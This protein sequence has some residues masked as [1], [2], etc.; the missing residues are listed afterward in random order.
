MFPRL[1]AIVA[2]LV[3]LASCAREVTTRSFPD[4][5]IIPSSP[6]HTIDLPG[7]R[8]P[9]RVLYLGCGH[10]IIEH[11]GDVM[12]T[13][14]F[15]SI[16]SLSAK[17]IQTHKEDYARYMASVKASGI[18]LKKASS[19]WIAHMHYDHVMDLPVLL[20]DNVLAPD[21]KI[22]GSTYGSDILQHF[23]QP[24]QYIPLFPEPARNGNGSWIAAASS[25]R[26]M[27][28]VS[29]HAPHV[30][31]WPITI[32][33]MKGPLDKEYFAKTFTDPESITKKKEWKEGDVYAF[34]V[35]FIHADTVSLRMFIQTSASQFPVG[36]PSSALLKERP[37]DV[38]VLCLASA[39]NVKPYPVEILKALQPKQTIFIHWEDLFERAEFGHYRLV[40][41]TNFRKIGKR[42]ADAG[43][44][45]GKDKY[46]MPQPGTVVMIR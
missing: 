5:E 35:D 25:I 21:V 46:V 36:L 6:S 26:V 24:G 43:M 45:L 40:R 41:L 37:V 1:V 4:K 9:V 8:P 33:A 22:H 42:M 19:V 12:V 27:S 34:L 13:D 39:N 20:R 23:I 15:F 28:I 30:K 44:T 16:Q 7:D 14:P 2:L 10:L 11:Q 29:E 3:L 32:H 38:A 18:D 17:K 31:F